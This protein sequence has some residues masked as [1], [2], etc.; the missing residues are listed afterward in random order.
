M[1]KFL[2]FKFLHHDIFFGCSGARN[3][4]RQPQ[5]ITLLFPTLSCSPLPQHY[6]SSSLLPAPLTQGMSKNTHIGRTHIP[7]I[8]SYNTC[9]GYCP[10][11][12]PHQRWSPLPASAFWYST[13]H[14]LIKLSSL[15]AT[16]QSHR[17]EGSH[18]IWSSCDRRV[19]SL[20]CHF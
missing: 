13:L 18:S 4:C 17:G 2:T 10:C 14:C 9:F 19:D 15:P 5:D 16:L 11:T 3:S 8:S 20:N 12:L 7:C 6:H 1:L